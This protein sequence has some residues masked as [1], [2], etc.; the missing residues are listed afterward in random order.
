MLARVNGSRAI[1]GAAI[2]NWKVLL[3]ILRSI[4]QRI[5]STSY[6]YDMFQGARPPSSAPSEKTKANLFIYILY[7]NSSAALENDFFLFLFF[8]LGVMQ[9]MAG[10]RIR[11]LFVPTAAVCTINTMISYHDPLLYLHVLYIILLS[12]LLLAICAVLFHPRAGRYA[13]E[14]IIL[15]WY[16]LS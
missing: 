13:Q 1:V 5:C 8:F 12:V 3:G 11:C 10:D 4:V 15:S 16:S 6:R 14:G 2:K 7:N 9:R